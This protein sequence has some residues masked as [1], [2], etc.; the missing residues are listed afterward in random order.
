VEPTARRAPGWRKLHAGNGSVG[1]GQAGTGRQRYQRAALALANPGSVETQPPTVSV[2]YET[3][4]TALSSLKLLS[5]NVDNGVASYGRIRVAT[6]WSEV[7]PQTNTS[8]PTINLFAALPDSIVTGGTTTLKWQI[9]DATGGSVADGTGEIAT[10]TNSG[11]GTLAVSPTNTT[12]YTLT[13]T[14]LGRHNGHGSGSGRQ[15][16][17]KPAQFSVHCH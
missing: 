1:G 14:I 7:V 8:P 5:F 9:V 6:T 12:A 16:T 13:A 17:V 11:T 4:V 15:R 2:Q 3:S 10:L